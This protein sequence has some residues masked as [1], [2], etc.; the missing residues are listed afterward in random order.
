[1]LEDKHESRSY[2]DLAESFY[3][4]PSLPGHTQ[5]TLPRSFYDKQ[6]KG[7]IAIDGW[8]DT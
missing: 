4:G 2:Q 1:M 6:P 8:R 7:L 5:Y 3:L